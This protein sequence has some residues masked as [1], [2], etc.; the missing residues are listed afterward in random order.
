MQRSMDCTPE[1]APVLPEVL[2]GHLDEH[3]D[4]VFMVPGHMMGYLYP[5]TWIRFCPGT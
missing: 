4:G 1:W 5:G 2:P 3:L